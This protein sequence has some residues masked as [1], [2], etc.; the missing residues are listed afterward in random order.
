M[1]SGSRKRPRASTGDATG[2]SPITFTLPGLQADTRLLV[3]DQEYRVHSLILKLHSAYFRQ[4]LDSPDKIPASENAP[5]KYDYVS[6]VDED[7]S[8]WALQPANKVRS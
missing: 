7:G 2:L 3:F 6:V 5:F 8:G 1:A 4:F